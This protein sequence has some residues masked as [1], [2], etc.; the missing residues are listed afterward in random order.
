MLRE[1]MLRENRARSG[2]SLGT[3]ITVRDEVD[4]KC[5]NIDRDIDQDAST[6]LPISHKTADTGFGFCSCVGVG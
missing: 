6:Q 5:F 3:F 2:S 1:C 4:M